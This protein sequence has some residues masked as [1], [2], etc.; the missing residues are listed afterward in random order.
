[1]RRFAQVVDDLALIDLPLQGGVHSWSGGRS[2]RTWAR[3]DRFLVSQGWLD[4]FRRAVQC[5]LPRPTSN[6]FPI[7]LKGGWDEPGTLFVQV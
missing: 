5:R 6:H 2:N 1:M 4:I 3:L 7:L